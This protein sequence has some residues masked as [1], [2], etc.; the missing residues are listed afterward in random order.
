MKEQEYC[1]LLQMYG[2][3]LFAIV[4]E[5][6]RISSICQA[7]SKLGSGLSFMPVLAVAATIN[8][9]LGL[10]RISCFVTL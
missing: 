4:I 9:Q 6:R 2:E 5:C 1:C 7:Q 8:S 10:L 3:A